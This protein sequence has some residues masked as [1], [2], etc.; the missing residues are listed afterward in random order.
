MR[1]DSVS[2]ALAT[3][4][5]T[6]VLHHA[7]RTYY[8]TRRQKAWIV[9]TLSSAV[10]TFGSLP[11]L[12]D[13]VQSGGDVTALQPR[14]A[15]AAI[16]CRT[17]QGLLLADLII[18]CR[19][20]REH[21]T[22]CWGWI[23][24]SSYIILLHYLLRSGAAHCFCLAAFMELPTLHLA[25]SF[26]HPRL[27]H[28]VLF[29]GLFLATRILFH[30]ALIVAFSTTLGRSVVGGNPLPVVFLGMA[31]PGH[32]MWFTQ[33][34]RGTMRRGR[35]KSISI[36]QPAEIKADFPSTPTEELSGSWSSAS[37]DS[38]SDLSSESELTTPTFEAS[39][40]T[41]DAIVDLPTIV[42]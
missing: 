21:V 10:T 26:L 34:V 7:L 30:L 13:V 23:H 12:W 41:W 14:R 33:S 24:H 27:R 39:G 35:S 38:D 32:V 28:D 20:Y 1:A 42:L 5:V 29:C 15:L 40:P 31:F 18:G 8:D 25:L 22:L 17:F 16:V 6:I 4:T 36:S 11:F 9:T 3:T 37:S 2:T 19:Y